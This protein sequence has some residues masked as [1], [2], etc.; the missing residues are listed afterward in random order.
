MTNR[1]KPTQT[2]EDEFMKNLLSE[3]HDT[4]PV[5]TPPPTHDTNSSG[6]HPSRNSAKTREF[7]K[8][9]RSKIE[10]LSTLEDSIEL[11]LKT[12]FDGAESWDWN[13]MEVDVQELTQV[14][15]FNWL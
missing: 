13:D 8:V 6:E 2:E 14:S 1:K 4:P 9:E 12:L 11:D 15:G 3:I 7:Q 10:K 5:A